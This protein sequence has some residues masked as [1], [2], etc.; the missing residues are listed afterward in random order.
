M[1]DIYSVTA[2]T[3]LIKN[4]LEQG[5]PFLWV[6]GQVSNLARPGSGHVYFSLKDENALINV[7][8]F[9]ASQA[10]GSGGGSAR[11]GFDPLT[12]EVFDT[13]PHAGAHAAGRL[14]NGQEVLC[15]GRI[16]VYP[17]RGQYQLIAEMVQDVGLGR[18]YLEFEALKRGYAE[19]GWFAQERKRPVP[20]NPV[21]VAVVSA[22]GSAAVRDFLR[23]TA[24]RGLGGEVRIYPTLVQGEEAPARI[25]QAM[26]LANADAWGEVLVLIRGGGS[27]EDLWA[28]NTA[29]VAEAVFASR[30][31][32][33]AGIGH[34]V[35][36]SIADMIADLR[37]ATPSHAAQ[38]LFEERETLEQ[39]LDRGETALLRAWTRKLEQ[40]AARLEHCARALAWFSPTQRLERALERFA[41]LDQRLE[42]A[43]AWR[44]RQGEARLVELENR[45]A[46]A[47][48]PERFSILGRDLDSLEARLGQAVD[49]RLERAGACL[50]RLGF[51][52]E[53]LDP[54]RPLAR[55][56]A[57]VRERESGRRL[58][59]VRDAAPGDLLD[60]SLRDG[61]LGAEVRDVR[62]GA[63]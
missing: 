6:R 63:E 20:R 61:V 10:R 19:K 60:I 44:L 15:G 13:E 35:D 57:L 12:G 58:R 41:G 31:P 45:L 29:P 22:P 17:P 27:L 38:L 37:A 54:A 30:L 3:A 53:A 39:T 52:L 16:S 24:E 2:L 21:R 47:F 42:R 11:D 4:N 43:Q 62:P 34:E 18:L 9:K 59:G 14:E 56:Y 25:A 28:F 23:L 55:G 26:E 7:V 49:R 36:T 8:W 46:R 50:D 40:A 51:G 1:A 33:L 48:G 32:V 5:F